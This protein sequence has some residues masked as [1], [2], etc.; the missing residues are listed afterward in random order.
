MNEKILHHLG[1]DKSWFELFLNNA[2]ILQEIVNVLDNT[3][4]YPEKK[5]IFK[6]FSMP[7][8]DIKVLMLGQDPYPQG[9]A[10]GIAFAV[11][12]GSMS[13]S[14]SIII[15]E[16]LNY[17][18]DLF[19]DD[20]FDETLQL[21]VDQGVFLL[22]TSLTV[23]PYKIG[24]HTQMWEP[25]IKDTIKYINDNSTAIVFVLMGNSA[26]K[27]KPLINEDTHYILTTCHPNADTYKSNK[28]CFVGSNIFEKIDKIIYKLTKEKIKW[29]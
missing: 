28:K 26:K 12:K 4:F 25:F 23:Q 24:S 29:L 13:S 7:L 15:D 14:L 19:I 8:T 20:N 3:K 6:V 11:P 5:N 22:N 18:S 21:W 1:I 17:T 27:F 16:L 2:D 9:L 10:T